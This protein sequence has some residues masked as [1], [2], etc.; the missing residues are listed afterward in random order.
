MMMMLMTR[1]ID[2]AAAA[3]AADVQRS[4][5]P[6][7]PATSHC[8]AAIAKKP[9]RCVYSLKEISSAD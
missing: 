8:H 3:A 9:M 4:I 1:N 7:L 5:W 2:A 6:M